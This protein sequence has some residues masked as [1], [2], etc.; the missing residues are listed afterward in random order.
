MP[1]HVHP[2]RDWRAVGAGRLAIDHRPRLR[3]IPHLPREGCDRVVTLLAEREGAREIGEAVE[4]AGMTWTWVPLASGRP[5]EGRAADARIREAAAEISR[6]LDAGEAVLVH[7]SA[8]MHRTGMFAYLLLRRRGLDRDEALEA[9]EA[10]RPHTRDALSDEHLRWADRV[11]E[12][13]GP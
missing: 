8:G 4:A 5:P 6:A 10:M 7:C 11:A 1:E 9:I 3:R 2:T 12:E 13:A